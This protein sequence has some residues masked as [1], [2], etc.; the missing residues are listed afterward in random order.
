MKKTIF[1]KGLITSFLLLFFVCQAYSQTKECLFFA[2]VQF[3]PLPEKGFD[4]LSGYV[5]DCEYSTELNWEEL[6]GKDYY[7]FVHADG[8][9]GSGRFWSIIYGFS[10]DKEDIPDRGIC[11]ISS[12]TGWR[13]LRKYESPIFWAADIDKDGNSEIIILDSFYLDPDMSINVET[14]IIAWVY[15]YYEGKGFELSIDLSKKFISTILASYKANFPESDSILIERR[16]M[17]AEALD[18]FLNNK[19]KLMGSSNH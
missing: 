2:P 5:F 9:H 1:S 16:L 11:L 13:T 10:S 18:D 14:G 4:D 6:R 17:A 15:K 8:P 3:L 19:C 12:T 7:L